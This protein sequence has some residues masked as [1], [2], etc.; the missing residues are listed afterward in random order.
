M[1]NLDDLLRGRDTEQLGRLMNEPETKKIFE[2]LSKS[3]DGSLEQ[4]AE[5]A[6]KGDTTQLMDAIRQLMS[7]PEGTNL[8]QK[9]KGKLK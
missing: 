3:T 4:A 8:I 6:A 5:K 2:I 1:S 9:I 7:N